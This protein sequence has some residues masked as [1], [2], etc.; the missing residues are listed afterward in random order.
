ME[1]A[2]QYLGAIDDLP[3]EASAE[4]GDNIGGLSQAIDIRDAGSQKA[5]DVH[6]AALDV[7]SAAVAAAAAAHASETGRVQAIRAPA[8]ESPAPLALAS[9]ENFYP[10][11]EPGAATHAAELAFADV[12]PPTPAPAVKEVLHV[13]PE[14]AAAV[15]DPHDP[16]EPQSHE[17][18]PHEFPSH[19]ALNVFDALSPWPHSVLPPWPKR[20]VSMEPDGG[21]LAKLDMPAKTHAMA[22]APQG[23]TYPPYATVGAPDPR[24]AEITGLI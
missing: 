15:D 6:A 3:G 1:A 24:V 20:L 12:A 4:P 13:A 5:L 16:H 18:Q 22:D 23:E 8:A 19:E 10:F 17:P 11:M 14:A 9:F 7:A 2:R 21:A